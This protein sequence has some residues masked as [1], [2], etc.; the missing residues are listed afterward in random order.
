MPRNAND[1]Y[2]TPHSIINVALQHLNFDNIDPWEP[3]AGDGRFAN[4]IDLEFGV[5]TLRH[6]IATG[7]DFFDWTEAQ[8]PDLITNPP[9]KHIRPFIVH[10]FKI[11]VQRMCLVGPERLWACKAGHNLWRDH[12]P[13]RFANLTWREDYLMRGGSPDRSLSISIWDSPH[14]ARCSFEIWD[15]LPDLFDALG[16]TEIT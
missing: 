6:D 10:A 16:Q 3:C 14:A 9:F 11:G 2:P 4:A 5:K 12:R 13:S 7:N 8:R 15:R 1:Y